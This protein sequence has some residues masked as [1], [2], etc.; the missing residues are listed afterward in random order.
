MRSHPPQTRGFSLIE[1]L[2][3]I[4]VIAI[5]VGLLV[6]ALMYAR[7]GARATVCASNLRQIGGAW[8]LYISTHDQFPRHG[9]AP[10][11]HYGGA[12]FRGPQRQA[13]L[14]TDRP[15]NHHLTGEENFTNSKL[16]MI[17]RCPTDAGIFTR[18]SSSRPGLSLLPAHGTCFETY[19]TSY[20]ANPQLVDARP[21]GTSR[22]RPLRMGEVQVSASRLLLLGDP[23]WYYATRPDTDPD[24][25][26]A[27]TWHRT[28]RAGNFAALD[29]SVRFVRFGPGEAAAALYPRPELAPPD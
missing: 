1:V 18:Q 9:M 5:L 27:A 8:Q 13:M 20:K 23:E 16:A 28:A 6:P 12:I 2:I 25:K 3:S 26:L 17:Y 29:G 19:G 21:P 22:P 24:A 11:W 14:A 7:D 15:I 10:D 4:L